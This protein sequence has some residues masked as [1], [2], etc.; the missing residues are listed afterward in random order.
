VR[1]SFTSRW[2]AVSTAGL[3][4]LVLTTWE[5]AAPRLLAEGSSLSSQTQEQADAKSVGC[6]SCHTTTDAKSMHASASVRL[7]CTDCHGGNSNVKV[8]GAPGSGAW[9]DAQH[10]AHVQPKND[11]FRSSANPP[12]AYTALLD[13][14]VSFV[15]FMNPGDLRAAPIACGPCHANE[16]RFVSKNPMTHGGMLYGAALYNNGVL[17]GKDSIVGESYAEDGTPRMLQSVPKPSAQ[18]QK[19]KGVLPFLV[20]FPRWELSQAGNPFRVFER[21]GERKLEVGVP[22]T[23]ESPGKPDKGLSPRGPGTLNRT[24]P[25][26]LGAQ[27][28]RLLDPMLSMLG[29]NDHPG[30]YRSSGCTACHVVYA[31]DRSKSDSGPY[32]SGGNRGFTQTTDPTIRKDESGHPLKHQFTRSIPSSQCITCHM[33]PGTNMVTTYL[34][35]TWWDNEVDGQLMYPKEPKKLSPRERDQMERDNPEGSALKGLWS[36]RNFLSDVSTLNAKAKNTQ[37][38]DF[39]GHGWVFRAVFSKDRKGNLLDSAGKVVAPEDPDKFRKAVHMKDIH[40]EKGMHCIDCHF[41]QDNHGNG[42]LYGEPRAAIE[43]DCIDCHGTT[44]A[45][46]T[47]TTT[48][49]AS[50]GTDL[51]SLSTPFGAPRFK[52]RGGKVTQNSMVTEGLSW[53][54]PQVVDI[55]TPGNPRYNARAAFAKTVQTDASSWGKPDAANLAHSN[56]KM[57]CY[58]CHSAWTTSCFGCH[59]SQRSNVKKPNLHNEGGETRNW[60]SYNFQTLRDDIYFLAKDGSV[61]KNRVAPARS[62]CAILVSSQNQNREWIYSQ[63]QTT[64]SGGFAGTSFS[65]YVPHTVRSRETRGC[66]DC[67]V[68]KAGDNN[69]WMAQLLMQGTGLVNFIGRYAYVGEASNGFEAVVVS[70]RD[71]PQAVIGSRLHELAYPHEYKAHEAAGRKLKEAYHHGGDVRSLQLR[72][73]YLF[74]AQGHKGLRIYDVAQIDQ[75][76]FSERLVTA[77]VSPLGQKLYVGTEDATSVALPT[78]MTIDAERQVKPENEEQK[79]HPIYD[80]AFVTDSKEGLVVVGPLATLLDGDPRNNFVKRAATFNEGG[81]L[82]GA[83]SMALAGTVG[84]VTTPAGIVVLDLNDPLRP[85]VLARVTSGLRAP[86]AVAVQFRYAFVLDADGLKVMDVTDP[87]AARVLP[88]AKVPF[89]D[90]RNLYLARTYAYVAAGPEGLAIVDLEKPEQPKLDQTFNAGGAINDATDVK[91]GM[92]NGSGFAYVA[93]GK[94][95]LRVVQII[96]AND[97]PGAYGFSP[98]PTPLLVATYQT[99]GPAI[100]LSRGLDRDRAVDETGNQIGVFGRR[101]ARPLNKE[102]QQRMYLRDGKP[103]MVSDEPPSGTGGQYLTLKDGRKIPVKRIGRRN[104]QVLLETVKGESFSVPEDDVVSPALGDIPKV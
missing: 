23:A 102:E 38:A 95:G 4:A 41:Q 65:T 28:T 64:S 49:P 78:T 9:K 60:I 16:V 43:I 56:S 3:A 96:S 13:E 50:P 51:T 104:G 11:I 39:H 76:G 82:G 101:G 1:V 35:Y 40:L 103:F 17:P 19:E 77:P 24:D 80:Y 34:G 98:R 21:G 54:V 48:G 46:A 22:D 59:L 75:K 32:A 10:Q 85:K 53:E 31:N 55:V 14:D 83:T 71:E 79:I 94:N 89:K 69:A 12:R 6:M 20:P 5:P 29:T 84:Y 57:T 87:A 8:S 36:D 97:T 67:H 15:R 58:A 70:E 81:A 93:D 88:D 74:A 62:A 72:G 18:E 27:K 90:A 68:S 63:Q 33:H 25:T 66:T 26:V 91:I 86:R 52:S 100:A 30:D 47:L 45:A 99:H 44:Q 37:F 73:E 7:G 61:T 2:L 42:K 92:T